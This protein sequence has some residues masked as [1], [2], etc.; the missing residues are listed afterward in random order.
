[1]TLIS[2]TVLL[3]FKVEGNIVTVE[4]EK[5]NLNNL[6]VEYYE[7]QGKYYEIQGKYIMKYKVNIQENKKNF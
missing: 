6:G 7:I 1:M 5:S 3:I 2:D 4:K